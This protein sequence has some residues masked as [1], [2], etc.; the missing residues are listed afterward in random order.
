M[1]G[2]RKPRGLEGKRRKLNYWGVFDLSIISF[3]SIDK[4][5][6]DN[7]ILV[8]RSKSSNSSKVWWEG[9]NLTLKDIFWKKPSF[10]KKSSFLWLNRGWNL[11]RFVYPLSGTWW[12]IAGF[13][14]SC[15]VLLPESYLLGNPAVKEKKT[16]QFVLEG[17]L[18]MSKNIYMMCA[19]YICI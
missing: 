16:W 8:E 6:L 2:V 12:T 15:R 5:Y 4:K 7:K 3:L 19:R 9:V 17:S 11:C 18:K 10:K 13:V 14:G 1:S